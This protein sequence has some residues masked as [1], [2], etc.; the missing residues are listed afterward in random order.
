MTAKPP[1]Y[2]PE[3]IGERDTADPRFQSGKRVTFEFRL[4]TDL[5]E[6]DE[7]R[8][9]SIEAAEARRQARKAARS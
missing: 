3:H 5:A 6:L 7:K 4:W 2:N 1:K 9:E 8:I